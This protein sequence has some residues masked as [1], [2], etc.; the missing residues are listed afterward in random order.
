MKILVTGAT[1]LVGQ[2]LTKQLIQQQH[3]VTV[4]TR[5]SQKA[6]ELFA[7]NVD[8]CTDLNDYQDFNGFDAIINLAGEPIF[9]H[10]WT[11][12]QKQKLVN[13]R[14]HL[15]QQLVQRINQSQT[16]PHT[17]ISGS[18][19]GYYGDCGQQLIDENTKSGNQFPAQL[20]QQWEQTALDAKTRVCLLRTGIVLAKQGGALKAMLPLYQVGLGGKLGNGKQYWAWISL[21]DMVKAIVFLLDNPACQG[22][23]NLVSPYPVTN[24]EFNKILAQQLKRPAIMAVP[25]CLLSLILG[26]RAQLLLDSQNA[27]P[28][29]LQAMGFEFGYPSLKETLSKILT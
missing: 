29:K 13:S 3:Q 22:S 26:E 2:Q 8:I 11:D 6:K 5:S 27:F 28:I 14:I 4:L 24:Q 18:A 25:R 21:E 16:P 12:K 17:F 10:Y 20:C 15:T 7:D 9:K 23:F 1:G 19:M